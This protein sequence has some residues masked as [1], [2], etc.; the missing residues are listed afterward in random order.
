VSGQET[1]LPGVLPQEMSPLLVALLDKRGVRVLFN[2]RVEDVLGEGEC[3][4]VRLSSGKVLAAEMFIVEDIRPDL[5]FLEGADIVVSEGIAVIGTMQTS[6]PSAYAVDVMAQLQE[7]LLVGS[8]AL[9]TSIGA[10]QAMVSASSI[11]GV[12]ATFTLD[13][14]E[15]RSRLETVFSS[16]EVTQAAG[17][18]QPAEVFP[19]QV[20][21]DRPPAE[22]VAC[23]PAPNP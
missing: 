13:P 12:A 5:R 2:T 23:D 19:Q 22:T 7:P 6:A 17:S 8:Y 11:K 15:P 20:E 16:Q 4:A 21:G 18:L 10:A 3:K 9:P 1:L 14:V